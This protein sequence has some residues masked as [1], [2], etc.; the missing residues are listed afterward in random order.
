MLPSRSRPPDRRRNRPLHV[1]TLQGRQLLATIV[2]TN[3]EDSGVGS[4]R[5]ALEQANLDPAEDTIE[6]APA[7]TGT[8]TLLTAL[9]ELS[10]DVIVSGPGA[11]AL[12]VAR[13]AAAG[14]PAFRIFAVEA[15]AEVA[16]S[17]LTITGG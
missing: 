3:T 5:A 14:T 4:L 16:I 8:I 13:S 15:G 6:F 11:S 7:V 12:A 9:P 1:E 2:V 10:T 17:G